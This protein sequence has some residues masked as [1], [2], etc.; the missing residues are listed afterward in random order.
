MDVRSNH[1]KAIEYTRMAQAEGDPVMRAE[2][3]AA[4]AHYRRIDLSAAKLEVK[5]S[6]P[7][8][9][10][11]SL[12]GF[13]ILLALFAI[14]VLLGLTKVFSLGLVLGL[15]VLIVILLYIASA[16]ALRVTGHVSQDFVVQAFQTSLKSIP[17]TQSLFKENLP[18]LPGSISSVQA[19]ADPTHVALPAPKVTFD[20]PPVHPESNLQEPPDTLN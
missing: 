16:L 1:E 10:V 3:I 15:F 20:P 11:K 18:G 9:G 13:V 7:A 17:G 5:Q 8:H 2:M 19:D 6:D 12:L 4:A 14:A